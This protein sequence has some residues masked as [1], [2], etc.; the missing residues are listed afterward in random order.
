MTRPRHVGDRSGA[1]SEGPLT[2][3]I[4][5]RLRYP[6]EMAQEVLARYGQCLPV[7]PAGLTSA[8]VLDA[9]PPANVVVHAGHDRHAADL[10]DLRAWLDDWRRWA[11]GTEDGPPSGP[12]PTIGAPADAAGTAGVVTT[13]VALRR[14]DDDV[15]AVL[16]DAVLG[17]HPAAHRIE[18]RHVAAASRPD[19]A[20]ES[21]SSARQLL[22]ATTTA[23]TPDEVAGVEQRH[24]DLHT[25]LSA[26]GAIG[27][28]GRQPTVRDAVPHTR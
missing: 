11:E 28:T 7:A 16:A 19:A 24:A 8:V 13:T 9:G 3:D 25:A 6:A 14:L 18:V 5:P 1:M 26:I 12:A 10:T 20:G 17:H 15:I 4:A 21:G 2:P 23:S 27:T 22:L